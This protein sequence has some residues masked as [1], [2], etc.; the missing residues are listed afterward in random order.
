MGT[1]K[2]IRKRVRV[3]RR[4]PA[5]SVPTSTD[6]FGLQPNETNFNQN[7]DTDWKKEDTVGWVKLIIM[8]IIIA[9]IAL[10]IDSLQ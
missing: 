10:A 6:K 4:T 7:E 3:R 9:I 8:I 5:T 2:K 1:I